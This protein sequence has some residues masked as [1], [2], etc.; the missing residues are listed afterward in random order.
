MVIETVSVLFGE[1]FL[2]VHLTDDASEMIF[3]VANCRAGAALWCAVIG[4]V[5]AS[6]ID[7]DQV[8][9]IGCH[10]DIG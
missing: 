5:A 9:G 6:T 10:D 2:L 4:E 1:A 8:C 3:I 7:R